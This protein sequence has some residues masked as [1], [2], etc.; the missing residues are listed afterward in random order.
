[1]QPIGQRGD[2]GPVGLVRDDPGLR[3]IGPDVGRG[4]CGVLDA[5][6]ARGG[7]QAL[8]HILRAGIDEL[9]CLQRAAPLPRAVDGTPLPAGKICRVAMSPALV[10]ASVWQ[11]CR[12]SR[13]RWSDVFSIPLKVGP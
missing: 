1:M 13:D 2:P 8:A 9:G 12:N 4:A 7:L 11:P 3:E 10:P 6:D 5:G